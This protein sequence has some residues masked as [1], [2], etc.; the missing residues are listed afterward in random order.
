MGLMKGYIYSPGEA[1]AYQQHL[2]HR[3]IF[4]PTF[5]TGSNGSRKKERLDHDKFR[6]GRTSAL[7]VRGGRVDTQP[8]R[9]GGDTERTN[10]RASDAKQ[11]Q[12]DGSGSVQD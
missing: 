5:A 12:R 10:A 1:T 2:I 11:S 9:R 8:L 3:L 4:L 6:I 7:R